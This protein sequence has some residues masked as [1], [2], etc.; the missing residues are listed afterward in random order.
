[1]QQI[2]VQ[3][4]LQLAENCE[5]HPIGYSKFLY[6]IVFTDECR[7]RLNGHVGT[8]N[9]RIWE[10]KRPG[11]GNQ[12]PLNSPGTMTWRFISKEKIIGPYE[13]E[14]GT[15]TGESYR[16][17]LIRKVFARIASLRSDFV[18]QPHRDIRVRAHLDGKCNNCWI[19]RQG[20]V[21]WF[22]RFPDLTPS[23]F[24]LWVHFKAKMYATPVFSTNEL[25]IGIKSECRRIRPETLAKVWETLKLRLN[26]LRNVDGGHIENSI[27]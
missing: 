3:H 15:V 21:E 22:A 27:N 25:K 9:A 11:E 7:L 13:V 14:D 2:E 1:M 10:T 18:F 19:G 20:P 6:R 17:L 8:Q 12:V 23:D 4:R 26:Y 16:Q 5:N 24:F